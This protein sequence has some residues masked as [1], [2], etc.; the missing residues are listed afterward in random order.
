[1]RHAALIGGLAL[2]FAGLDL[3]T[4]WGAIRAAPET[5][6]YHPR[7]T[8]YVAVALLLGTGL[9]LL[10]PLVRWTVL[11]L[12]AAAVCGGALGNAASA[13]AW[14][15][16][17]PDFV[18]VGGIVFNLAD[19]LVWAGVAMLLIAIAA[20]ILRPDRHDTVARS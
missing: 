12:A 10:V 18:Q 9:A 19:V 20:L 17:V 4:K 7:T 8:G 6:S 13:L 14:S 15:A 16:G 3:L 11:D 5:V 2:A 1:M